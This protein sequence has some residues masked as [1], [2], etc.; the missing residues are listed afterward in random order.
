MPAL[1]ESEYYKS[2]GVEVRPLGTNGKA[3]GVAAHVANDLLGDL[4][5]SGKGQWLVAMM[6]MTV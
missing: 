6:V 3:V 4:G 1:N 5:E 2:L